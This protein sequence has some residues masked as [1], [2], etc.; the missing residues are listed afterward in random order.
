MGGRGTH[1]IAAILPPTPAPKPTRTCLTALGDESA[2]G[3]AHRDPQV[4]ALAEG[5][6]QRP[7][8]SFKGGGH[9]CGP[10]AEPG[11]EGPDLR[12]ERMVKESDIQQPTALYCPTHV[13]ASDPSPA[14][15]ACRRSWTPPC[16]PPGPGPS[17][18]CDRGHSVTRGTV[19]A[20]RPHLHPNQKPS[21]EDNIGDSLRPRQTVPSKNRKRPA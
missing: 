15:A 18:E 2:Q 14:T 13:P 10:R 17:L 21:D 4:W 5:G 1:A 19:L 16:C 7:R 9:I 20:S 3:L 12:R 8:Q 11:Q 6:A